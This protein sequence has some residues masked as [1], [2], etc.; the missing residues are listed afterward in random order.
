LYIADTG[1]N[2]VVEVTAAG[3]ASVL[4]VGSPGGTALFQPNSVAVDGAGDLFIA[5]TGNNRVV[6]VTAA[7][8]ASVLSVGAPGGL[9]QKVSMAWQ[10]M[11]REM[12]TLRTSKT[13]E[14]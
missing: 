11:R 12:S 6:G 4:N 8:V 14:L 1:N 13:A 9:T 7:G 2:R 5:D 3:V 10:W